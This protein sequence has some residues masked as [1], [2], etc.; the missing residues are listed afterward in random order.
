MAGDFVTLRY[1]GLNSDGRDAI[2]LHERWGDRQ[3]LAWVVAGANGNGSD[4]A[5]WSFV[6][7]QTNGNR[8]GVAALDRDAED[9]PISTSPGAPQVKR[10][11][12]DLRAGNRDTGIGLQRQPTKLPLIQ[13]RGSGVDSNGRGEILGLKRGGFDAPERDAGRRGECGLRKNQM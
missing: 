10:F 6:S 11:A 12:G 1:L 13:R 4:Q 3:N 7:E 2:W 8:E 9:R 5:F